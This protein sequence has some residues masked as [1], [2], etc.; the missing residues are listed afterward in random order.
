MITLSDDKQKLYNELKKLG[1]R[2]NQRIVR[3]EREF[4]TDNIAIKYIK[5]KLVAEPLQA[6]SIKGRVKYNK[7]MSE[8]QMIATLKATNNFLNS[9]I[10]TKTGIKNA[11]KKAVETLKTKFGSETNTVTDTEALSLYDFFSDSDVNDITNYI[12]GS[13]VLAIIESTR[14][15]DNTTY[16]DFYQKMQSYI[17]YNKDKSTNINSNIR[18]IYLKYIYKGNYKNTDYY[19]ALFSE[20]I[21]LIDDSNTT[22]EEV[23]TILNSLKNENKIT[24]KEYNYL[25]NL[26]DEKE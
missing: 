12:P 4:G 13:D 18:E 11:K 23:I 1:K 7:S 22:K 8:A 6:W 14:E 2:A 9:T 26:I 19:Q 16:E 3:L 25:Q 17:K 20:F 24:N 15:Q 5:D 21:A 10:S